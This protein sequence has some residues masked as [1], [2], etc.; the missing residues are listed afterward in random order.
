VSS[1]G[2]TGEQLTPA[3]AVSLVLILA[4]V[5]LGVLSDRRRRELLL[6]AP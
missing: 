2:I 6:Q 1:I 5:G 3:V 4:G